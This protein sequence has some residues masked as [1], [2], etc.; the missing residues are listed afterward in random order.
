MILPNSSRSVDVG[1]WDVFWSKSGFLVAAEV[2]HIK[3][4][5]ESLQN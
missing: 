3:Q 4:M 5:S 1:M 2:L